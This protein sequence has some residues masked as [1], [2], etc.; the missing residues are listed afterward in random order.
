MTNQVKIRFSFTNS[1]GVAETETMWTLK[2]ADGY[3]IDNIPFYATELAFGDLIRAEP[4]DSEL[5]WYAGL[6]SPSGHSTIRLWFSDEKH[7][8]SVRA[9]L[10]QLGC[11]SEIS[12]LP[13]LVAVDVPP[14]VDYGTVVK[15]FLDEGERDGVFE[16]EEAC[17]GSS[18]KNSGA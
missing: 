12:D 2:Q 5:L 7:V 17:L 16:Y 10:K 1:D 6:N 11:G 14:S 8:Q 18:A 4:D 3:Q 13:R 15:T 9:N